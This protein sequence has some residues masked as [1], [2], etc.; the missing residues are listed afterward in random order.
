[1]AESPSRSYAVVVV[2]ALGTLFGAALTVILLHLR[3]GMPL[4]F[5]AGGAEMHARH[6]PHEENEAVIEHMENE[7]SLDDAQRRQIQSILDEAHAQIHG[8]PEETHR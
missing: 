1:M 4:P 2:F 6:G 8:T 7:L 5:G 3:G